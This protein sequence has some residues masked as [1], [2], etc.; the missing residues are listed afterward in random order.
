VVGGVIRSTILNHPVDDLDFVIKGNAL[1]CARHVA[2]K[3]NAD[4]F[5]LDAK[6]GVGR[7]LLRDKA[8]TVIDISRLHSNGIEADM[9]AR[10]FTINAIA[11]RCQNPKEIVDP[12]KGLQHIRKKQIH[13]ISEHSFVDDPIRLIRAIRIAVQTDFIIRPK[14]VIAIRKHVAKLGEVSTERVRDE[15]MRCLAGKKP[16]KAIRL[17]SHLEMLK[18]ILVDWDDNS[19]GPAMSKL[20]ALESLVSIIFASKTHDAVCEYTLGLFASTVGQFRPELEQYLYEPVSD[21]SNKRHRYQL[22]YIA[23]LLRSLSVPVKRKKL[24]NLLKLSKSECAMVSAMILTEDLPETLSIAENSLIRKHKSTKQ[25]SVPSRK[26]RAIHA[27][28]RKNS[29]VAIEMG[30]LALAEIISK[31]GPQ[32]PHELWERKLTAMFVLLDGY[33]DRYH[34]LIQPKAIIDGNDLIQEVGYEPG[35][36]IG[37][38]LRQITEAQAAGE[39]RDR[40]SALAMARRLYTSSAK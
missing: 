24:V 20:R 22:M 40:A 7:V 36:K 19:E 32:I 12:T 25:D 30:L 23:I 17:L 16:I 33:F 31:Y 38:I 27:Y 11:M 8:R 29:T 1:A 28:Y 18:Y 14:T 26:A 6:R 35:E 34:Q 5:T 37:S 9:L 3:L 15:F 2:D 13:M 4:Y 21:K 39:V 10:D